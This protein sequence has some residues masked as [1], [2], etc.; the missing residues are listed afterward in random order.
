M[1]EEIGRNGWNRKMNGKIEDG[2]SGQGCR[3]IKTTGFR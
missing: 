2:V 3:S 1:T